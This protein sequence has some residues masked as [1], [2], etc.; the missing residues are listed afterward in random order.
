MFK[1]FHCDETVLW[2]RKEYSTRKFFRVYTNRIEYNEPVVR[3]PFGYLGCG[4]WNADEIVTNPFDRGAFGFRRVPACTWER[5]CCLWPV[6]GGTVA[7]QRCQ[8]NGPIWN[9]IG[10]CGTYRCHKVAR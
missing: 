8:C 5:L 2:L 7:R 3:F 9:R 1:L 10:N 4:S 6:Y